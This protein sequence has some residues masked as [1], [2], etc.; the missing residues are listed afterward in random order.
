MK[1]RVLLVLLASWF[2]LAPSVLTAQ[3]DLWEDDWGD[4]DEGLVWTGFVE[5][6]FGTRWDADPRLED[7]ETL[8]ELTVRSETEKQFGDRAIAW[9]GDLAYDAV[10]EEWRLAVRELSFSTSLGPKVE[11]RLGRQVQTWGTG[12]LVFLNDLFPKD[13]V[14]FFAGRDDEYLK[15]PADSVRLTA[16]LGK[17]NLDL[18]WTPVFTPDVYLTGE[19]FSFFSGPAGRLVAPRPPAAAI[20]PAR[21]FEQAEFALRLFRTVRGRE[22]A[23]YGYHGF[24]KGPSALLETAST[25]LLPTFAPL[26]SWGAS[27]RQSA[28]VGVL[29]AELA[30][31]DS[32]DDRD[33][34]DPLV[35]NDQLRTLVG[36]EWEARKGVTVGLQYAL[37]WTLDYR[38]LRR[39]SRDQRFDPDE[40]RHLLTNRLTYRSSLGR[41]TVSLFTFYSPSDQDYYF[42]PSLHYRHNDQWSLTLGASVL[43]GQ[44]PFTFFGQL[45][46]ASNAYL[47]LRFSY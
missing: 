43:G 7:G 5:A 44:D 10:E 40:V 1:Y 47:R 31:Y 19:R 11:L 6:G 38:A 27:L 34:D 45:E 18:V 39:N 26:N 29:H 35:P 3:E 25:S 21:T 37:D 22:L 20:E 36:Y 8:A 28:G 33:G 16:Y 4:Q 9:S 41:Y 32:I 42:R 46:D 17:V 23:L 15:S 12:D 13:F 24:F 30:Y 2:L 14:S